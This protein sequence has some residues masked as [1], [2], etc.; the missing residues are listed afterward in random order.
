MFHQG[1]ISLMSICAT[2]VF[3]T[4][5]PIMQSVPVVSP[6]RYMTRLLAMLEG[7]YVDGVAVCL[8]LA[9]AVSPGIGS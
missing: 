3:V 8:P 4:G 6:Y 7:P 5:S 1:C 2:C 9:P